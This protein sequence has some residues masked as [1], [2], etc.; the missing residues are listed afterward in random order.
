VGHA[1]HEEVPQD[2]GL[3]SGTHSPLQLCVFLGHAP[4]QA[5]FAATHA[6]LHSSSPS[7]HWGL[8]ANPSQSTVPPAG[9]AQGSHD[10][11]PQ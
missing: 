5:A 2:C 11:G 3:S 7:E 9:A 6:P 4:S 10:V 8:Q 1:V